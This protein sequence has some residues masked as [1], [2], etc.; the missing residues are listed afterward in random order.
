MFE[1]TR[2]N[3]PDADVEAVLNTV[4]TEGIMGKG[5]ALQFRKAYPEN[6]ETYQRACMVSDVQP[7]CMFVFD[8]HMLTPPRYIINFPTK[9]YWQHKSRLERLRRR[10]A[11]YR[12]IPT[13]A[14]GS[15]EWR[16][17]SRALKPRLA[18]I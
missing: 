7:G 8:R 1:L 10:R 14:N 9:R 2:G 18:W 17:S 15:S 13:H 3:L 5:I 11:F 16:S 12:I 6:Y 4:N